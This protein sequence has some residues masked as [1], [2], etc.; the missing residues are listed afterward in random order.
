MNRLKYISS[1]RFFEGVVVGVDDG[2]VT[3]DLKGRMGQLKVPRRLV[4]T[5]YEILVGQEVGFMM[6]YPEVLGPDIDEEYAKHAM[7]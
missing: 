4:I 7:R 3:I 5:E 2:S 6:T 1:E